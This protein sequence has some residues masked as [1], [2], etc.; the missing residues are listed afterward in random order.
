MYVDR[1]GPVGRRRQP[2]LDVRYQ[3]VNFREPAAGL[4]Q[5]EA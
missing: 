5:L 4:V 3:Q 2:E 1:C